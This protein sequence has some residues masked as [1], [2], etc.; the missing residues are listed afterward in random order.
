MFQRT[1][2]SDTDRIGAASAQDTRRLLEAFRRRLPLVAHP[3]GRLRASLMRGAQNRGPDSRCRVT[4]VFDAGE[5]FG[6]MCQVEVRESEPAL[7]VTPITELTFDRRHP[8]A[9]DVA[10]YRRRRVQTA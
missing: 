4:H 9:R 10:D 7:L 5:T 6:L 3:R 2:S 1:T 8:L